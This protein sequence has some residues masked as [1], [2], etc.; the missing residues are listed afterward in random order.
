MK[1]MRCGETGHE[2]P[3]ML[4]PDG[5]IRSLEWVVEDIQGDVL[6]PAGLRQLQQLNWKD[7]PELEKN[8]RRG[9]CVAGISKFICVGLNYRDHAAETGAEIP[10]EPVIFNKWISAVCGPE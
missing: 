4:A 3:A 5:T 7:L 9:A 2:V 10:S 8:I 1:L 6:N